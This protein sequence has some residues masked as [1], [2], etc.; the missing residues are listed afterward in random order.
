MCILYGL[1]IKSRWRCVPGVGIV[2]MIVAGYGNQR[3]A[4]FQRASEKVSSCPSC[5]RPHT[6]YLAITD[7][8]HLGLTSLQF[9]QFRP[10]PYLTV[11]DYCVT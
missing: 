4:K 10:A 1:T 8:W 3:T 9:L 6:K 7:I 2:L 5:P 11:P